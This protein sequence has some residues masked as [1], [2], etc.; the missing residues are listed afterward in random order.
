[1]LL[2]STK[3]FV[4]GPTLGP[5]IPDVGPR[6]RLGDALFSGALQR[7]LDRLEQSGLVTV[8]PVGNQ[9]HYQANRA[10]PIFEELRGIVTKTFGVVDLVREALAP[11]AARIRTAFIYGS[12][13]KGEDTAASDIDL[14]VIGDDVAYADLFGLVSEA[15]RRL[16][17][18]LNP[19]VYAAAEWRKKLAAGNDFVSRVLSQPKVFI[20]GAEDDLRQPRKARRRKA[21]Q[22]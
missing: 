10:A 22:G 3:G 14:M 16:G 21:A 12:I 5:V 7:E 18:K 11:L 4:L 1:V 17:R 13:A 19:T 15:E 2:L 20:I 9:K 6:V 8:R